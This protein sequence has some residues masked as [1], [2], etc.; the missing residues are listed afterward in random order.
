MKR[1]FVIN[2]G[3]TSTKIAVYQGDTLLFAES[4]RHTAG[5]LAEC[6]NQ[7]EFRKSK[8]FEVMKQNG[9][10]FDTMDAIAARGGL[11][12]PM[13]SGTYLVNETMIADLKAARYGDHASNTSGII[14]AEIAKAYHLPVYTVNP[15]TVDEL[16]DIARITGRPEV[17]RYCVWHALN[18]K[19]VAIKYAESIGKSY[20]D[21]NL[22]V[23]HIGGGTTI[24]AHQKGRTIDVNNALE[25]EGPFTVERAGRLP[26][27]A[28]IDGLESSACE[29]P[30]NLKKVL[31]SW[32]GAVA[33]LGTNSGIEISRRIASGDGQ[34]ELIYRSIAYQIS[35]DI[36]AAAATLSGDVDAVILTGGLAY[37][38]QLTSWIEARI[39][40]IAPISLIPGEDEM[41][42]LSSGVLRV[43]DGQEIAKQY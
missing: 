41:T 23:A 17:K 25:G 36:G 3:S 24:G 2:N 42:A 5:E 39:K 40:F 11:L 20:Q 28:F 6:E 19:A 35:R 43:L 14:A 21:L 26:Y 13:E 30:E 29:G 16:I 22:I 9:Y 1:I 37:D 31:N 38:E 27:F 32:S 7:L 4:I 12:R 10:S 8:I 34:A 33:Y 15:T 18:Q